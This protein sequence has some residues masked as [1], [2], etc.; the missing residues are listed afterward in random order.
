MTPFMIEFDG[1]MSEAG[2][3]LVVIDFTA[4]WCGPCKMI[5]PFFDGLS[6]KYPD[7]VFIKVDVDDAQEIASNCDI[8][9]MPT[10]QFYKNGKRV[11]EFSGAN[12]ATLEEKVQELK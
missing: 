10:F 6:A 11:H 7:V 8:K 4:T 3:K 9:C 5:G 1:V 2:D 12:K